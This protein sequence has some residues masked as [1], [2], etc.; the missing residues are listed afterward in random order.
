MS[1]LLG[2]VLT[3]WNGKHHKED[4][5]VVTA[6]QFVDLTLINFVDLTYLSR[7]TEKPDKSLCRN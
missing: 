7:L 3:A 4:K 5:F 2:I 1:Y 6:N